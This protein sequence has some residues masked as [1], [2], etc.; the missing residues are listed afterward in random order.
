MDEK[1]PKTETTKTETEQ[2]KLITVAVAVQLL[3]LRFVRES[4][5]LNYDDW[6][7]AF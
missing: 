7:S 4:C 1:S 5:K 2:R 6:F 3:L